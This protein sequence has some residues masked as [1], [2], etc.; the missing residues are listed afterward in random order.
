MPK[1]A[2]IPSALVDV[3]FI[4]SASIIAAAAISK[5]TW[6]ELVRNGKAPQPVIRG[7][8]CTRWKL[9]DIRD[10]LRQRAERGAAAEGTGSVHPPRGPALRADSPVRLLGR[11]AP[12]A[13]QCRRGSWG[14][15]IAPAR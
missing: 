10:W 3:A 13:H 7:P 11:A 12:A 6:L 14:Q 2:S 5:S 8:R 4:D 15:V 1:M 9:S